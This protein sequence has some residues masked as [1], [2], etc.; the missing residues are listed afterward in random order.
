MQHLALQVAQLHVVGVDDAQMP[1]AGRG[2][3]ERGR[4][5]EPAGADQQDARR[6]E[7]ALTVLADL[8]QDEVA[9]IALQLVGVER[10]G[11]R[12]EM[13]HAVSRA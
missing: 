1:D 4:R 12:R 8:G 6:L 11:R 13:R 10:R 2:E 3:V 7:S 5:A 9:V